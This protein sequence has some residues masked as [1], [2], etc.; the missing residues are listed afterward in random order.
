LNAVP[1]L[2]P[3]QAGD[4]VFAEKRLIENKGSGVLFTNGTG[5][6]K[7]FTGLGIVARFA[8]RGKKNIIVVT[9]NDNINSAWRAA[10]QEHF[11]LAINELESTKSEGKGMVVTTFA[12][13][14]ANQALVKRIIYTQTGFGWEYRVCKYRKKPRLLARLA[15]T[16][17]GSC[18]KAKLYS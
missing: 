9:P 8:A 4:V 11:G 16:I 7:T 2:L 1:A 15:A 12:N 3:A 10:A 17:A 13:F 5:T 14:G 18:K 6:G